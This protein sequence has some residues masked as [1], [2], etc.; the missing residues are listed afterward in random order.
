M[1]KSKRIFSLLMC[2]GGCLCLYACGNKGQDNQ[3]TTKSQVTKDYDLLIYNT[4]KEI[5][6]PFE[7][8]CADYTSRTGV[9]LKSI[10]TQEGENAD[11]ELESYMNSGEAPDIYTID[12]M[13]HLKK[14][15]SSG[16]VLDFSNATEETFKEIANNIPESIRLSSNTVDN[17]GLPCTLKGHGYVVD[18][19]MIS[20][21]FG[22]DKY[23]YVLE[24]LKSCTYDEFESFVNAL[25]VYISS[26]SIY[27]FSLHNNPYKFLDK[28]SGLAENLNAVF[29]F[30]AGLPV[31]T[32]YYML[33]PAL[34]YRFNS[35]AQ[36]N[37]AS[38][39]AILGLEG[40]F[41]SFARVLDVV[42][43]SV[44]TKSAGV[45]R[46][47]D[48]VNSAT[49]NATQALKC[50]V[51]GQ[52]LFLVADTSVYD[53]MFLLD[54]SLANRVSLM[55]IKFPE[56]AGEAAAS[57]LEASSYRQSITVSVPFYLAINSKSDP[58]QQKLAQDFLV[59][60]K[61]SE[62]AQKYIMQ[63][64]KF[65]PYDIKEST[66]IDNQ[67][68]RKMVEYVSSKQFLPAVCNGLPESAVEEIGKHLIDKY[69]IL[70]DWY[71]DEYELIAQ[72]I[73]G[74]WKRMK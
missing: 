38:D 70:P 15:Q 24:D 12:D 22:S 16:S 56:T 63:E 58:K 66:A 26:G 27:E 17:F 31:Y 72:E 49:N 71:L 43:S 6:E 41:A 10:T 55:P 61:T 33:S 8:M 62:L 36:A 19:K 46:G 48:L 51:N 20:S 68:S 47:I 11:T 28:R 18:P 13:S 35:A 34:A 57:N 67:L 7:K 21:L 64:F 54:S 29:A 1:G 53:S 50:F 5:G 9:I 73:I 30:P 4:H 60:F 42:T 74:I 25:E 3:D 32:G 39:E 23:R 52:A 2:L 59:W 44:S 40:I 45:S 37:V 14:W 69:Y 65:I